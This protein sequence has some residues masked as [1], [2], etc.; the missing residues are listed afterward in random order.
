MRVVASDPGA[1]RAVELKSV[2]DAVGRGD[3]VLFA[4]D[5]D[6]RQRLYILE[7][8]DENI[9]IGRGAEC[10][11]VLDWDPQVSR[12][13]AELE[14]RAG[15]WVLVDDG[16]S[17]NGTFVGGARLTG[18]RRLSDG[19]AVRCGATVLVY[20]APF[21]AARRG[22]TAPP[23]DVY[24]LSRVTPMQR[25]VLV[26][27]CRPM[28]DEQRFALPATN[29]QIAAELVLSVDAVKTH[30]RTLYQRLELDALA[31]S[32]KRVRLAE[33]ALR[34]GLVSPRELEDAEVDRS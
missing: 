29:A 23:A 13:H 34:G 16:L 19:D 30:L 32:E 2:L 24:S 10:D 20:R 14:R 9:T 4:H 15:A 17:Q 26:A 18:R 12:L 6:D 11:V 7:R 21:P 22:D 1:S 31:Q 28:R 5:A 33:I 27:L 3:H 25:K 8:A